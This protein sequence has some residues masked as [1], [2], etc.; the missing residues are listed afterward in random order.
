MWSKQ[1][2]PFWFYPEPLFLR[3]Y[4]QL[5]HPSVLSFIWQ[6]IKN[7]AISSATNTYIWTFLLEEWKQEFQGFFFNWPQIP[8]KSAQ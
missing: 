8:P 5:L 7:Y 3:V 4:T 6:I 2:N 1:P